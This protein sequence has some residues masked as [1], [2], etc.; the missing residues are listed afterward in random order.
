MVDES[1]LHNEA[2]RTLILYLCFQELRGGKM[3]G[4]CDTMKKGHY[5]E[6]VANPC[7]S[8]RLKTGVFRAVFESC[9]RAEKLAPPARRIPNV[10]KNDKGKTD[11]WNG[12]RQ[13]MSNR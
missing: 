3:L 1:S 2:Y 12:V 4:F 13:E 6:K 5:S 8:K 9:F 7:F 11:V 10:F